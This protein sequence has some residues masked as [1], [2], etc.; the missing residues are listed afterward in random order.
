MQINNNE[1]NE[2]PF[3]S[4]LAGCLLVKNSISNSELCNISADFTVKYDVFF[5][6]D[7]KDYNYENI[8]WLFSDRFKFEL[9]KNYNDIIKLENGREMSV[10]EY[11]YNFTHVF[12]KSYFNLPPVYDPNYK[13]EMEPST[14]KRRS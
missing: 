3:S 5:G 6:E 13:W 14:K 9:N 8:K 2:I 1:I 12:V 11:L 10:Y 4:F 7:Y